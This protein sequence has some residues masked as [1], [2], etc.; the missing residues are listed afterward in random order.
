MQ[1]NHTPQQLSLLVERKCVRCGHPLPKGNTRYCSQACRAIHGPDKNCEVCGV[2]LVRV[3]DQPPAWYRKRRTCSKSCAQE[4]GARPQRRPLPPG[5]KKRCA[6][7]G[8][9]FTPREGEGEY[10]FS[11]RKTCSHECKV[12][13]SAT[14][15]RAKNAGTKSCVICGKRFERRHNEAPHKFQ[16]RRACG[17]AC[18]YQ[19]SAL[20]RSSQIR[21]TDPYPVAFNR[22]LKEAIR[23]RDG[24]ACRLCGGNRGNRKLHVHHINYQKQD[25]RP[26]N[27]ISLCGPCHCRTHT[28]RDFWMPFFTR[29]MGHEPR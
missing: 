20:V 23:A 9:W 24:Q 27:L 12:K 25:C 7:C 2:P 17:P 4:L 28:N 29:M 16:H 5:T 21:R 13:A 15:R 26:E 1:P 6:G 18:G 19:L 3:P 8:E 14:S 10:T 22:S 11:L